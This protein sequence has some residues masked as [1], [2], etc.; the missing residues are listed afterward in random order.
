V[1]GVSH[2]TV[3]KW[4]FLLTADG[5]LRVE[6]VGSQATHRASRYRYTGGD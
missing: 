6:S 5:V 2:V 3:N 1:R 4:L